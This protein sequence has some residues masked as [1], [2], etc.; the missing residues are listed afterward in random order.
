ADTIKVPSDWRRSSAAEFNQLLTRP[1]YQLPPEP[2]PPKLPPPPKPPKPPPKPP[3]PP[4]KP[5]PLQPLR[6]R[7]PL[8]RALKSEPSRNAFRQPPPPL[9]PRLMD[10]KIRMTM[11]PIIM[12][13]QQPEKLPPFPRPERV[14]GS[15]LVSLP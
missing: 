9:P 5:P 12:S 7:P 14:A 13:V 11:K 10:D 6:D 15:D 4:P 1:H 8:P 2:P 3:P